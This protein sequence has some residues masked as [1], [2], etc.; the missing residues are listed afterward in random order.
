MPCLL[1]SVPSAIEDPCITSQWKPQSEAAHLSDGAF[2]NF[3]TADTLVCVRKSTD[4]I[5]FSLAHGKNT[6]IVNPH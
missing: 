6:Y 3:C 4:N 5:Y 1:V 2:S